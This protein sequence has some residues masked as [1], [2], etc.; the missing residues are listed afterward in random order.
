MS[1]SNVNE[2]KVLVL[3][4][5]SSG[6]GR[7]AALLFANQGARVYSLDKKI[8]EYQHPL[9][10][11]LSCDV[12]SFPMVQAAFEQIFSKEN[13]LDYLFANAGIH[14]LG[15]LEECSPEVLEEIL[16]VNL[17]GIYW[18]LKCALPIMKQQKRGAVVLM[19]SDQTFIGKEQTSFYGATKGAIGQLAKSTALDY[20]KYHI[21]VNCICPGTVDTPLYQAFLKSYSARTHTPIEQV[22]Q[23]VEESIPLKRVGKPEEIAEVVA[24]LCSDKAAFITGSLIS[25]DGGTVAK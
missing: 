20:A 12:S 15:N 2:T 22:H 10:T 23:M 21:R 24:F 5:G 13:R 6:I 25:V 8:P 14:C 17:K 1:V 16:S 11:H 9:I 3:T 7:A 4:G 18:T 19:G